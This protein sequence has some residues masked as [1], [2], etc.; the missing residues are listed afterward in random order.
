M[1]KNLKKVTPQPFPLKARV[2]SQKTA[3]ALAQARTIRSRFNAIDE[4]FKELDGQEAQ[5]SVLPG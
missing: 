3:R 4:L 2:P 5:G 1:E